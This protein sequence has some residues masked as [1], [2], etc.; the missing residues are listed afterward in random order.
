MSKQSKPKVCYLCGQELA[1]DINDDHVPPRQFYA[2]ELR[3][4]HNPNLLTIPTHT[5]CNASYQKDEEY[6]VHTMIPLGRDSY[7]GQPIFRDVLAAYA[8]GEKRGLGTRVL[9]EF[10]PRPSGLYLP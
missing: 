7:S 2:Q 1:G 4:T 6:F 10:D 5:S 8:Q 3:R 9:R